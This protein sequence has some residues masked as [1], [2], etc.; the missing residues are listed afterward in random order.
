[1]FY[2]SHALRGD[3]AQEARAS[4]L[5]VSR[6]QPALYLDPD[7]N[8]VD[9]GSEALASQGSEARMNPRFLKMMP[10]RIKL[11][12]KALPPIIFMTA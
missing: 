7:Q 3:S 5:K 11:K 1:M 9:L 12:S 8:A 6:G 4:S 10:T 2:S